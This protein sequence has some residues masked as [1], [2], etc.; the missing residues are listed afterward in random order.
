[1]GIGYL[2]LIAI[3]V[4]GAVVAGWKRGKVSR[5]NIRSILVKFENKDKTN[6]E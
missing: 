4:V 6:N 5:T 2:E 1:M 3:F